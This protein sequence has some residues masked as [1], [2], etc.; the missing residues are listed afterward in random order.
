MSER[1]TREQF[2]ADKAAREEEARATQEQ[3]AQRVLKENQRR[4]WIS[5]GGTAD[6]FEAAGLG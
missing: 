2:E 1:Y 3:T 4:L 5:E 6:S